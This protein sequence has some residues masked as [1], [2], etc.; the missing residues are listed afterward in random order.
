MFIFPAASTTTIGCRFSCDG[1]GNF[2]DFA[3][4]LRYN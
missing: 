3:L 4:A 1:K 2:V